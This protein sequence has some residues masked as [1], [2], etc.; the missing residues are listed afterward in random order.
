M[1]TIPEPNY[2]EDA[3]IK[4]WGMIPPISKMDN[5]LALIAPNCERLS[6]STNQ[7]EKIQNITSFK[8]INHPHTHTHTNIENQLENLLVNVKCSG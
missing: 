4:M 1:E 2:R 6:L 5:N 7:I 3:H 8:V